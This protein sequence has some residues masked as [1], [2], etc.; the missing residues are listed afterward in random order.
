M[1]LQL[2]T[3]PPSISYSSL[4]IPSNSS[5]TSQSHDTST[6]RAS[7]SRGHL[8]RRDLHDARFQLA[9]LDI[10]TE[11]ENINGNIDQRKSGG[12]VE[13]DG[14]EYVSADT[15]LI[16]GL[17]EGGLKTWEGGMDL[18]NILSDFE[19]LGATLRGKRILEVS[20]K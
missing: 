9:S 18:V 4:P 12:D 1:P 7:S 5:S 19:D 17:Y 20:S 16:P 6:P 8:L 14:E 3:L 15:D 2:D 10:N 13:D 11:V